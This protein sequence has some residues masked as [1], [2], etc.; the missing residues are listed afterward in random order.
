MMQVV[1]DQV[2]YVFAMRNGFVA[3]VLA[4]NMT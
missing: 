3:A 1:V 4:V 2:V